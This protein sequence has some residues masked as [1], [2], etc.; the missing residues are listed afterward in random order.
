MINIHFPSISLKYSVAVLLMYDL[1]IIL[2]TGISNMK[3]RTITDPKVCHFCQNSVDSINQ[4]CQKNGV[5][6]ES[7][8][9]SRSNSSD[10]Q[11]SACQ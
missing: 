4:K 5:S 10:N 11:P 8:T 9:S 2:I 6:F 7:V 1:D 3:L